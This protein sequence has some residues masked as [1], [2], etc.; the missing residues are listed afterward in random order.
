MRGDYLKYKNYYGSVNFSADDRILHGKII[1]ITDLV[2]YEATS[3]EELKNTFEESVED[4]LKTCKSLNKSPDK[5][6]RCI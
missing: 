3:V 2:T 6:S 1:G 5:F 4:Y